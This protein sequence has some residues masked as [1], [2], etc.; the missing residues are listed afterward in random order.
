MCACCYIQGCITAF[1][2]FLIGIL[3]DH[4]LLVVRHSSPAGIQVSLTSS[5]GGE[6]F[7]EQFS[8]LSLP[9]ECG[10]NFLRCK[11]LLVVSNKLDKNVTQFVAAIPV[12]RAVL[13]L[14]IHDNGSALLLHSS[15]IVNQTIEDCNP[16]AIFKITRSIYTMCFNERTSFLTVI[17]LRIRGSIQLAF[18]ARPT[19][20]GGSF[21]YADQVSNF[22]SVNCTDERYV[23]FASGTTLTAYAPTNSVMNPTYIPI[24]C[25][26]QRIE[27]ASGAVFAY[28]SD[29]S[30]SIDIISQKTNTTFYNESGYPFVCP[31]YPHIKLS[32]FYTNET[33]LQYQ[34]LQGG[35]NLTK[36]IPITGNGSSFDDSQCFGTGTTFFV[37]S[38]NGGIH[39]VNI[40]LGREINLPL[41][42][43][44]NHSF[45][46]V[47]GTRYMVIQ[48]QTQNGTEA[49]ISVSDSHQNLAEVVRTH[50]QEADLMAVVLSSRYI[51]PPTP[52]RTVI[53][54]ATSIP[55]FVVLAVVLV[56][57]VPVVVVCIRRR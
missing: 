28:C 55:I 20:R 16:T 9:L 49:E 40:T 37:Y 33:Y 10:E 45:L 43:Y 3:Y 42:G 15:F 2:F 26:P 14:D 38:D 12:T 35:R 56:V 39:V 22:L 53:I 5:R 6:L 24:Q 19:L 27:H 1:H 34:D 25:P 11:D 17:E 32:A 29:R 51:E 47:I 50:G 7:H 8:N 36:V 41:H 30:L 48:E 54:L 13:L 4:N 31:D 46:S 44:L 57:L 18:F 21:D 23:I 52:N